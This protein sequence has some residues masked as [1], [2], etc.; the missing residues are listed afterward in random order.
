MFIIFF[1]FVFV[2][3]FDID[4]I[5][6]ILDDVDKCFDCYLYF[7]CMVVVFL[8]L[9]GKLLGRLYNFLCNVILCGDSFKDCKN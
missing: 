9:V 1:I 5:I 6:M 4:V 7:C 8:W 2:E 3:G